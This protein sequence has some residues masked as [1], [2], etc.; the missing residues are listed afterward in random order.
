V[1]P[2]IGPPASQQVTGPMPKRAPAPPPAAIPI[3][4]SPVPPPPTPAKAGPNWVL[5]GVV[6]VGLM[7]A[8]G[9]ALLC[10]GVVGWRIWASRTADV[11]AV[12]GEAASPEV[13]ALLEE[14][15]A[16]FAQDRHFE[17]AAK[18]YQVLQLDPRNVEAERL[19]FVACELIAIDRMRD[20]LRARVAAAPVAA[21]ATVAVA[22]PAPKPA[23]RGSS[24]QSAD[25]LFA[26]G[27]SAYDAG[28]Y[29]GAVK[30][31][32]QAMAADPSR[33]GAYYDA[34]AGIRRAKDRMRADARPHYAVG[35]EAQE[36]GDLLTAREAFKET[37]RI[38]PYNE[39]A[40]ARLKEV[41]R[42]IAR[43]GR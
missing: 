20:E 4:R 10:A 37:V 5:I 29:P 43:G 19:A 21:A 26:K 1:I 30:A 22:P 34:E 6:A 38:D 9:S 25:A 28:D 17:A 40:A 33:S 41:E 8:M 24:R 7:F 39:T 27:Q 23:S 11:A 14:G 13:A 15:R 42:E 32:Q 35:L 2:Q 18:F 31:W 16:L 12:P 3:E 36:E